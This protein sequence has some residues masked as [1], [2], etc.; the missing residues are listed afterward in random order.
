MEKYNFHPASFRDKDGRVFS[1]E[2][3][4]YRGLSPQY[5]VHYE[6][7]MNSG[8]YDSL[9]KS[10]KLLPATAVQLPKAAVTDYPVVL[11]PEIIPYISYPYEWSFSQYKDA[12]LTTL[13][14]QMEALEKGLI[15]KDASAYNIQFYHH[16]AVLIDISS[17]EIY[18]QD[19][20][21]IAYGQFC[22]HFLA[23]LLLM[24]RAGI[25]TH[26]FMQTFID[27][28]P[29]PLTSKLLP[30]STWFSPFILMNIHLHAK[31]QKRY[32]HSEEGKRASTVKM[33]LMNLKGMIDGMIRFIRNLSW[34][35]EG[36]WKN[37]YEANQNNYQSAAFLSKK[38]T[39]SEWIEAIKPGSV[40]DLGGN[41]GFFS[42][43]ASGKGI[44]TVCF[45]IDPAAVEVNYAEVKKQKEKHILPLVMDLTQPSPSIGWANTER[46]SMTERGKPD[47]VMALALIHHLSISNNLPFSHTAKWFASIAPHLIIEFVP[48]TDS[49]VQKLL[50][51]RKDIFDY[52][53]EADFE[54]T[55][56]QYFHLKNKV[57]I[58]DSE[59]TLYLWSEK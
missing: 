55:F 21:W 2:G 12:A 48:K 9:V 38:N 32:E 23:P 46:Q 53:N 42:R 39:I 14:I 27:G 7:L 29:L 33:P 24:S 28:I 22:R 15:L 30:F 45:D 25:E 41:T 31:S 6:K 11:R 50:A 8:L 56:G 35:P 49:Q 43:I 37:Y 51:T 18:E 52:Y 59:R 16:K 58:P 36:T 13:A 34:N 57:R 47:V 5:L 20:P 26:R 44:F 1:V 54:K 10:G 40:W 3:Q 4:L 19:T 17:F